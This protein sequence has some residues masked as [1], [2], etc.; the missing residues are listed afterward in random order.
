M[1]VARVFERSESKMIS[2]VVRDSNV[3]RDLRDL[4]D[5]KSFY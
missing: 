2:S 4:R 1:S 3:T 5:L